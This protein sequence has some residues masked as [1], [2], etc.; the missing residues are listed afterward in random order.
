MKKTRKA[1][2][3][4]EGGDISRDSSGGNYLSLGDMLA[5]KKAGIDPNAGTDRSIAMAEYRARQDAAEKAARRRRAPAPTPPASA[6]GSAA[7]S[8]LNRARNMPSRSEE[9]SRTDRA[10]SMSQASTNPFEIDMR[11][12]SDPIREYQRTHDRFGRKLDENGRPLDYAGNPI[13]QKKG[14]KVAKMAKGGAA[15]S[16]KDMDAGSGGGMGRIEKT[17]IAKF[18]SKIPMKYKKGGKIEEFEGSARDMAEDKKL[19]KKRGMSLKDWEKSAADKKH[20]TQQSMKGLKK[21]GRA[22]KMADGGFMGKGMVTNPGFREVPLPGRRTL[23]GLRPEPN[24]MAGQTALQGNY[25]GARLGAPGMAGMFPGAI[26]PGAGG[27]PRLPVMKKGGKVEGSAAEQAEDKRMAKKRG[28][29]MAEWERSSADVKHDKPGMKKGGKAEMHDK[30][31]KCMMCGGK[32]KYAMGG[33]VSTS[34]TG[35]KTPLRP[36]PTAMAKGGKVTFGSMKPLPG[37]KT[38]GNPGKILTGASTKPQ[39]FKAAKAKASGAAPSKMM[40]PL[41]QVKKMASGGKVRG[42]GIAQRGT[43]FIGEV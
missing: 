43:K 12:M 38:V 17:A 11:R 22:K 14:G 41:G 42:T 39:G 29:S 4:Y 7:G 31:C 26:P 23:A 35:M 18:G 28:M 13:M 37:T 19:A 1:K 20:D 5:A 3:Y 16:Y 9:R 40:K 6:A 21:G 8:A 24:A 32:A 34:Q 30:G 2:G 10:P 25:M 36:K 33:N 27:M 15:R